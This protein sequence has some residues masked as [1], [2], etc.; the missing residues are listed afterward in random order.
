MKRRKKKPGERASS[1]T[2]KLSEMVWEFAGEFIR[3]GDSLEERQ[4]RLNAA[5]SA[6][7]M[8][9]NQPEARERSLDQYVRSFRSFNPDLTDEEI[10]AVREDMAKLVENKLRLFPEVDKQIIGAQ[11][12]PVGGRDRIDVASTK[13]ES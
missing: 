7:N 6:W 12:T 5:C 8:A 2:T 10:S 11:L 9:C 1:S 13:F 3:I 4:N